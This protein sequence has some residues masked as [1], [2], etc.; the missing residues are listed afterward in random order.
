MN[1]SPAEIL[2]SDD[3]KQYLSLKETLCSKICRNCRNR[4]V[5]SFSEMLAAL[6]CFVNRST[7]DIWKRSLVCGIGWYHGYVCV[8]IRQMS[9]LLEKCKSSING[10]M[11]R[12]HLLVLQ[13]RQE[14]TKILLDALPFLR[15]NSDM[16]KMWSVRHYVPQASIVS[17]CYAVS[18]PQ[19]QFSQ[20][21]PVQNYS[22]NAQFRQTSYSV[23]NPIIRPLI[24]PIIDS[25][26][27]NSQ[28]HPEN[29]DFDS[30]DEDKDILDF[31]NEEIENEFD[32]NIFEESK[33]EN[34]EKNQT[35]DD[36]IIFINRLIE[37]LK[38]DE[39]EIVENIMY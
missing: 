10:S 15:S 22:M 37:D 29:L 2:T 34:I 16:L 18:Y 30:S 24:K 21:L 35:H 12:L 17:P 8:N 4:R 31:S 13:N 1:A 28:N 7:D 9:S 3:Y 33:K 32:D 39:A 25:S 26:R 27:Y 5:E 36:D 20:I 38:F 14:T 19:Y 11:Q 6:N 23:Q